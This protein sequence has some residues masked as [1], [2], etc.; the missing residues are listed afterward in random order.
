M[1]GKVE[2]IEYLEYTYFFIIVIFSNSKLKLTRRPTN[3]SDKGGKPWAF[4]ILKSKFVSNSFFLNN[5]LAGK[6]DTYITL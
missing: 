4:L 2:N 3:S 5:L 6:C 1:L